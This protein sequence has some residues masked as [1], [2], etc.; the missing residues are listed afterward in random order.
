MNRFRLLSLFLFAALFLV[1]VPKSTAQPAPTLQVVPAPLY[2]AESMEYFHQ[3]DFNKALECFTRDLRNAIKMPDANGEIFYWLDSMAYWI[4]CGECHFQMSRYDEALTA[5]NT[6]LQIYF[7][8]P[9]WLTKLTISSNPVQG[10]RPA[11]VWGVSTR[12]GQMG[13]FSNCKFMMLAETLDVVNLGRDGTAIR[14][15]GTLTTIHADEII[16]LMALMIRRRAEILG[17]LSKYDQDTKTLAEILEGRPCL[18][19]HF[20]GAWVDVLHGLTLSALN[21]D[22]RALD[23]LNRGTLMQGRLDHHLTAVALNELGQILL[24]S[25]KY[26][27]AMNA[28]FEAS[29]SAYSFGDMTLLGETFQNMANT[30]KM[31]D[32]AKTVPALPLALDFFASQKKASP[33][34]LLPLCHELAEDAMMANNPTVSAALCNQATGIMGRRP[35]IE[36]K[37]GVRNLYLRAMIE[38]SA[39]FANFV[40]GRPLSLEAADKNLEGSLTGLRRTSLWCYHLALVERTPITT[41]GALTSRAADEVYNYLLREPSAVD[42]ALQ[43]MDCLVLTASTP[44]SAYERWFAIAYQT[45]P[46]R[47][48]DI[49]E[50][51]R[52]AKFFSSFRLGSRLM[53]LRILFEGRSDEL[54]QDQLLERQSLAL[55][56]SQF[57][58]L[59]TEIGKIRAELARLPLLVDDAAQQKTQ[60]ELFSR[61]ELCSLAQEAMLRSIALTRAKS[62]IAF[63]PTRTIEEIRAELPEQT[64]LLVFVEAMGDLYGYLIDQRQTHYWL[65]TKEPRAASLQTLITTFLASMGNV[66]GNRQLTLKE[67]QDPAA[68]W[69][70]AGNDLF[71]RLLGGEN[72]Q[73]NFSELVVVP[74][75]ALWYV[76]FE[77]LSVPV[78]NEEGTT[79]LRPLLTASTEPLTIRYAPMASLA[80]P[81]S[82][83]RTVMAETLALCG[84]FFSRSTTTETLD[85]VD[86][87]AQSGIS[88]LVP[89]STFTTESHYRELPASVPVFASQVQRLLVLNDIPAG[90]VPLAWSPFPAGRGKQRTTLADWFELPLGGPQLVI[91]PGFHTAAESALKAAHRAEPLLSNGDDLFLAAMAFEANGAR[92]VLI[93]RWRTGGRVSLGLAGDFLKNY[94]SMTAAAAWR[95]A[96]LNVGVRPLVLKEEPRVRF[97]SA[98]SETELMAN[99]PFF[100][101]AFLLIDRGD[102]ITDKSAAEDETELN[103]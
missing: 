42:W 10:P 21:D 101:G 92:T 25:T 41:R 43:P 13:N 44:S 96:I 78:T 61:L 28:F 70:K 65:V 7:K 46:E 93:S 37:H 55:E 98:E 47:A 27:E 4:M 34:V 85:A 74:T 76:P 77:A 68:P 23:A 97:T 87:Y 91:L 30:Q 73:A 26:A 38:Y 33:L 75:G 88:G 14:A 17:P 48:F 11:Y 67:L 22:S 94:D 18:P 20:T 36:S 79:D 60:R 54:A 1:V 8:Q 24:R 86:R 29:L 49:S 63:P 69:K 81:G 45:D 80:L 99:H 19:N 102:T 90:Q 89:L 84:R 51:A 58:K 62:S 5:Y 12:P 53:S 66:D 103:P 72:R 82:G 31:I 56:F 39:A 6:A 71:V 100:W 2:Y 50:K 83:Q 64:T 57:S 40:N 9:A 59:S 95:E 3:G 32:R 15:G 35:I 16:R 52:R